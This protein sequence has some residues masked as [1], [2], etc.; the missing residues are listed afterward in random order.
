MPSKKPAKPVSLLS[1]D[2]AAALAALRPRLD[3]LP[4]A[5]IEPPR[6]DVE[7]AATFALAVAQKAN[8]KALRARFD[9]LPKAEFDP[10]CLDDLAGIARATLHAAQSVYSGAATAQRARVPLS[11]AQD[12]AALRERLLRLCDYHFADD[13]ALGAEV[14]DIRRGT[15]YLDLASDL[16]RLAALVRS[17]KDRLSR[18]THLYRPSDAADASRLAADLRSA[19]GESG[20][21][22]PKKNA[23]AR[24]TLWRCFRL[25]QDTYAEV[26]A[27]G[28]FLLRHEDAQGQ[29][30]SL[31]AAVVRDAP[32]RRKKP[33]PATPPAP[34]G[35]TK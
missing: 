20:P 14:R 2:G 13:E 15:G 30:P 12:T 11:L 23:A 6:M 17:Q 28:R 35:P 8:G 5:T 31:G 19:L 32:K 34:A 3:R 33:S 24:E 9:S 18:D 22:N 7:R 29:F 27:A 16:D 21:G 26:A 1:T 4:R 10:A 25:L